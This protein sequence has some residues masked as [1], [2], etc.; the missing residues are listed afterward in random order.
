[1]DRLILSSKPSLIQ[2][3]VG[4]AGFGK[5]IPPGVG[6]PLAEIVGKLRPQAATG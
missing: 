5:L 2:T 6:G 4:I 1:M 3:R